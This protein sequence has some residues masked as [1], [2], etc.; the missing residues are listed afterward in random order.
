ML[1][2]FTI[3]W[4]A[5]CAAMHLG[6][7]MVRAEPLVALQVHRLC[8]TLMDCLSGPEWGAADGAG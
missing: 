6:Q 3:C 7:C 5:G 4:L 8:C 2:L 1:H